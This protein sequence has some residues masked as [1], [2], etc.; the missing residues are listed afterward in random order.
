MKHF[1]SH[2]GVANEGAPGETLVCSACGTHFAIPEEPP[3]IVHGE[4]ILGNHPWEPLA[5]VSV[6]LG[7]LWCIPLSGVA[8]VTTGLIARHR[9]KTAAKRRQGE[10]VALLG[11]ALGLASMALVV[12]RR[13]LYFL[14]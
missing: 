2:C 3:K 1:C 4:I 13:V 10:Q 11:I 6:T 8:A 12:L 9:I 14:W 7:L 5:I